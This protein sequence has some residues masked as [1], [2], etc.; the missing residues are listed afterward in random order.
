MGHDHDPSATCWQHSHHPRHSNCTTASSRNGAPS[1][2]CATAERHPPCTHRQHN[3][4]EVIPIVRLTRMRSQPTALRR[5]WRS[6]SRPTLAA[7]LR[8]TLN[9][10]PAPHTWMRSQPTA[11]RSRW[12][13]ESCPTFAA[14]LNLTLNPAPDLDA[15]PADGVEAQVALHILFPA[16]QLIL[17]L[18]L[19]PGAGPEP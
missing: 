13:S 7:D 17:T 2:K 10:N 15:V 1:Q 4:C 12:R 8:L 14:A 5:R 3:L 11:S 19:N 6:E 16:L 18:T 9:L